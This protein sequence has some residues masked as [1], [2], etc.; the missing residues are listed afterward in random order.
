MKAAV[1]LGLFCTALPAQAANLTCSF[2]ELCTGTDACAPPDTDATLTLATDAT[3]M[4][5][6]MDGDT[7]R[8][9]LAGPADKYPVTYFDDEDDTQ[10]GGMMMSLFAD[11]G[12]AMTIH[13]DILGPFTAT[14]FGTC[15]AAE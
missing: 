2:T 12:I 8:M 13:A 1:A 11:G 5:V 4:D 10:G 7:F 15:E 3:G 6:T 14:A 9:A